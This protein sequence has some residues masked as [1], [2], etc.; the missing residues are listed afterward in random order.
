MPS[1]PSSPA[2]EQVGRFVRYLR[3]R[4]LSVTKP[5][6]AVARVLFSSEGHPSVE[7]IQE[8]LRE[9]AEHVG[10]ATVYRALDLL[11]Q[12]GL[13]L[14]HDFGE[15][16]RR[17]EPAGSTPQHEHL[18]CQRCGRVVEFHHDRLERM[19]QLIAD[20][21]NFV[22]RRHRVEIHGWCAECQARGAP[23]STGRR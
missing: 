23:S 22:P 6:L 20:E 8:A 4:G 14:E 2:D 19:L 3:E 18:L 9:R 10:T 5:R 17:F 7:E 16:F 1:P 15:P 12:S 13:A 11:V 21:H